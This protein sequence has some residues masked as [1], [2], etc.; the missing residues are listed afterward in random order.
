MLSRFQRRRLHSLSNSAAGAQRAR[1]SQNVVVK[2][3]TL[4]AGY[5]VV[6]WAEDPLRQALLYGV[7]LG[8]RSTRLSKSSIQMFGST[9]FCL[10]LG[11]NKLRFKANNRLAS[12]LCPNIA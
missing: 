11:T 3:R 5:H 4:H 6:Y 10:K 7:T 8:S 2:W 12:S 1:L 9:P